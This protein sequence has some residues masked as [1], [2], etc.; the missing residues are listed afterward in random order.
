VEPMQEL[1][2]PFTK[3]LNSAKNKLLCA[4]E[5]S[6]NLIRLFLGDG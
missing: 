3:L 6:S 1:E 2:K 5:I 4:E